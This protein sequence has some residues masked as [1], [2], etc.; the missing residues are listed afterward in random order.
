MQWLKDHGTML[1]SIIVAPLVAILGYWARSRV[2]SIRQKE[3][4]QAK[5]QEVPLELL[6]SSLAKRDVEIME[7]RQQLYTFIHNHLE[8]DRVERDKLI[9]VLTE[10]KET[11]K[12]ISGDLIQHRTEERERTV[13]VHER[14]NDMHKDISKIQGSIGG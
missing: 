5:E 1:L 7:S 13:T 4:I 9:E 3:T 8:H 14:L 11:M 6:K 12:T 2:D 10:V